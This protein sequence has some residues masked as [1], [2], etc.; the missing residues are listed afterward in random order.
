[1]NNVLFILSAILLSG[2]LFAQKNLEKTEPLTSGETFSVD[3]KFAEEIQVRQWEKPQVQIQATVNIDDGKGNESFSLISEKSED[4]LKIYSDFGDYFEQKNEE[5][6]CNCNQTEIRYVVFVP[7]NVNLKITSIT[8]DIIA[9]AFEGILETDLVSGDVQIKK[10]SGKL[11][12]KTVSGD[13]DVVLD[14]ANIDAKSVVGIIYSDLDIAMEE[15][16]NLGA[17]HVLGSVNN[18]G[19]TVALHTVSGNIYMRRE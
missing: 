9:D 13:L 2:N 18:G 7:K 14:K 19:P 11:R 10:Y 15:S 17:N 8:G 6:E 12:L 16:G 3:F 5:K 4:K 1:M